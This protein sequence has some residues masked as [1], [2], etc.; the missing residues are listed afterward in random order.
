MV[1]AVRGAV[2]SVDPDQPV[3]QIRTMTELVSGALAGTRFIMLLLMLF[4]GVAAAL[5]VVGIYGVISHAVNQRTHEIG[6]RMALGALR[7]DI[8]RLVMKEGLI[9]TVVGVGLGLLAS[10]A[11]TQV[12][13]GLLFGVSAT[14]PSTFA[15]MCLLILLV[16]T[17]ASWLPANR[18]AKVD[19]FVALKCE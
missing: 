12:L 1:A 9:L 10:L 18:A 3:Y 17:C 16:A 14:D 2:Q 5:A 19:P 6:V 11:L 13:A 8:L 15:G 7:G 4:A